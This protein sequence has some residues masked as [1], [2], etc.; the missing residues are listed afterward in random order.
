MCHIMDTD[1][2]QDFIGDYLDELAQSEVSA[3]DGVRRDP[4]AV[5][6]LL[7]SLARNISTGAAVS[8]LSSDTGGEQTIDPRTTAAY[9]S[10][11]ERLFV[12]EDVPA[13]GPQL[14][15]AGWW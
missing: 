13:W 12:V 5:A 8:T 2:A 1:D 10:A 15:S 14:R 9:L 7:V 3:V 4:A 11:L 6:R